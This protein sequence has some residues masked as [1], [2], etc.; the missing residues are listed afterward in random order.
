MTLS[1]REAVAAAQQLTP[2]EQREVIQVLSRGLQQQ[3]SNLTLQQAGENQKFQHDKSAEP[4][5]S[6]AGSSFVIP[7]PAPIPNDIRRTQPVA[8]LSGLVAHFWPSDETAD[9]VNSFIAEQ[10]KQDRLSDTS[11]DLGDL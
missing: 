5:S 9:D 2:N 1:V 8:D 4:T 3:L 11:N 10:R 6:P 7:P